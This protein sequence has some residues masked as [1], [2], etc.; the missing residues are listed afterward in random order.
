MFEKKSFVS[1]NRARRTKVERESLTGS[2]ASN[3]RCVHGNTICGS[4]GRCTKRRVRSR[5]A[6]FRFYFSKNLVAYV[7]ARMYVYRV[8]R[9]GPPSRATFLRVLSALAIPLSCNFATDIIHPQRNNTG[10]ARSC[11]GIH[12]KSRIEGGSWK[13]RP[14]RIEEIASEVVEEYILLCL[15]D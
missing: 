1:E 6:L 14:Q 7:T 9:C 8:A 11:N 3:R 12:D 13:S 10:I 5:V 4:P 15:N 2:R